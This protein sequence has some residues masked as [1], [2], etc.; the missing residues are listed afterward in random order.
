MKEALRE[1]DRALNLLMGIYD[2]LMRETES[3][4]AE[5]L[6]QAEELRDFYLLS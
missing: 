1:P 5:Y 2:R 6:R 4:K 3:A